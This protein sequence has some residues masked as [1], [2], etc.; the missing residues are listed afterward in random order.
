MHANTAI[1]PQ[2]IK[3]GFWQ[4]DDTIWNICQLYGTKRRSGMGCVKYIPK[5]T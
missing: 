5:I 3:G 1:I 4:Y 2:N